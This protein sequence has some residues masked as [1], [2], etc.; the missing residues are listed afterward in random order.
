MNRLVLVSLGMLLACT[1]SK[2]RVVDAAA[3]VTTTGDAAPADA[4]EATDA[5]GPV[6]CSIGDRTTC[7]GASPAC[8]PIDGAA[9]IRERDGARCR[10]PGGDSHLIGCSRLA[11]AGSNTAV[12]C[13]VATDSVGDRVTYLTGSTW[14]LED[15]RPGAMTCVENQDEISA[16]PPC[17]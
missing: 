11:C 6:E 14:S 3:D 8:C 16:L 13:Y 4:P 1:T 7:P 12:G 9:V 5:D 2:S 10:L 15:L 17:E